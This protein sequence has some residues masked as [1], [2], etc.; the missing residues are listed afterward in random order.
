MAASYS[1]SSVVPAA[2]C[3]AASPAPRA[4]D[5]AQAV[6][7]LDPQVHAGRRAATSRL[8]TPAGCVSAYSMREHAAPRLAEYVDPIEAERLADGVDLLM[9]SSTVQSVGVVRPVAD[10]RSPAGRKDHA[11]PAAASASNG[12]R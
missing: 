8:A 1:G 3:R 10:G 11:P 7:L 5:R 9:N 12:S 6:R 4:A 2:S